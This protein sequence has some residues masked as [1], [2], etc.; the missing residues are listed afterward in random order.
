MSFI[1]WWFGSCRW[2]ESTFSSGLTSPVQLE[3]VGGFFKRD[4]LEYCASLQEFSLLLAM[5]TALIFSH[6]FYQC[7]PFHQK[8]LL[9]LLLIYGGSLN[10]KGHAFTLMN[11]DPHFSQS[12][13]S[14]YMTP[15]SSL[16]VQ[17]LW[18]KKTNSIRGAGWHS[19]IKTTQLLRETWKGSPKVWL[20]YTGNSTLSK[21][22]AS[23][24]KKGSYGIPLPHKD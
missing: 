15:A 21:W 5:V 20:H 9:S 3:V 1:P 16:P 4:L 7:F 10:K 24:Q 22:N 13:H 18:L 12:Q 6:K 11:L 2:A 14:P 17:V 23:L 19:Q 8:C